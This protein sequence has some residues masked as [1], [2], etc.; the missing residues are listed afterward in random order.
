MMASKPHSRRTDESSWPWHLP[1]G[2]AK[3]W[4]RDIGWPGRARSCQVAPPPGPGVQ[5]QEPPRQA[6][7]PIVAQ[8]T[9][10]WIAF[11]RACYPKEK[12]LG[13]AI[14]SPANI[15]E[16]KSLGMAIQSPANK[17]QFSTGSRCQSI[18]STHT[19]TKELEMSIQP[20][21]SG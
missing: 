17:L 13:M 6:H 5:A 21:G 16:D 4:P 8:P 1:R 3:I 14:Q 9:D 7:P 2:R 10:P 20:P 19:H 15:E 12:K 18:H 11:H